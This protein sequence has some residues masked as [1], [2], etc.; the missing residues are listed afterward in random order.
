[1]RSSDD[2]LIELKDVRSRTILDVLRE[3]IHD[4]PERGGGENEVRYKLIID[5]S[6]DSSLV[7][8]LMT[9]EVL[10]RR[11]TRIYVCSDFPGDGQ[12]QKVRQSNTVN[13]DCHKVVTTL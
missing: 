4:R 7:R 3:S 11:N 10:E 1:M 6:E 5:T 8:L 9:F 13:S 12:L 2:R